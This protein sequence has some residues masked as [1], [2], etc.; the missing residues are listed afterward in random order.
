[1]IK[2]KAIKPPLYQFILLASTQTAT[3]AVTFASPTIIKH[4]VPTRNK[5]YKQEFPP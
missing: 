3:P 4:K 2:P 5:K 1:M